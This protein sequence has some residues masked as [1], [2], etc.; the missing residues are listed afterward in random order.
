LGLGIPVLISGC[1]G[2]GSGS[3]SSGSG[4][5]GGSGGTTSPAPSITS[6]SPTSVTA[7][8]SALT[9]TVNG[10]DFISSSVVQ[11]NGTT[12]ATTYV[13]ASQLTTTVPASEMTNGAELPVTVVS[14]TVGSFDT[15]INLEID[16]PAPTITSISPGSEIAGSSSADVVVTGTGFDPSTVIDINGTSRTTEFT[17]G[18]QVDVTL[19]LADLASAGTLSL[20]AINPTPGGGAST[21]ATV[22]VVAPNPV[23][24]IAALNPSFMFAAATPA[25]ITVT[26]SGFLSSTV[27]DIDGSPRPTTFASATQ[28]G[29]MPTAA[30]LATAGS[31]SLTAVNPGPGGGGSD[32]VALLIYN[33]TV[34]QLQ[35]SPS[36]L[37]VGATSPT[38]VTVT[39]NTFVSTSVVQVNGS[40]RPTT[41]VNSTT[42]TFAATVADQSM[43]GQ[44]AVTV[45]NPP[46]G[47]GTS[48]VANLTV[49]QP[50]ATPVITSVTPNSIVAGAGDT[51]LTVQGTGFTANS[52]VQW[53]GTPLSTFFFYNYDST[54]LFANVPA[55]DLATTGTASVTVNTP[56]ANPSLSN[57]VT[58][59]I[60]NPPAPGVTAIYPNFGPINTAAAITIS[61]V[62]FTSNSAVAVNGETITSTYV[63][64]TEITATIPASSLAFPG[65][66]NVTVT[67]PAPGGGTS[68][69]Q[70]FTVYLPITANDIAFDTAN[71]LLYASLPPTTAGAFGQFGGRHRSDDRQYN[72]ADLGRQ[73]SQ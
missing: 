20:T 27:I 73:Q 68:P 17:S 71:G 41:F 62:G 63:S 26:G 56:N 49:A 45:I 21:P 46:P 22:A 35:L 16:N 70:P 64:S 12:E 65:N 40:A 9:L 14:G 25:A 43:A 52:V 7:G 53:N 60:A 59:N 50:P 18:N 32:A 30:D 54:G 8:S 48:L 58:V 69:A 42:L 72:A 28:V 10:S 39:G 5:S 33:P 61:G 23:P 37:N 31:L 51:A 4:G 47:G 2:G 24:T 34:G 57:A 3:G 44:L 13:S 29:V 55:A 38:I 66:V 36:V 11:V 15:P 1:T 67:T 6:I 19:T